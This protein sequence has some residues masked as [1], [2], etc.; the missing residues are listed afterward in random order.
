VRRR[1]VVGVDGSAQSVAALRWAAE[2]AR[3]RDATLNVITVWRLSHGANM[4]FPRSALPAKLGEDLERSARDIQASALRL[5]LPGEGVGDLEA[6]VVEGVAAEV[7]VE[8]SKGADMLVL[9]SR[10]FGGFRGLLLGSIDQLC[11]HRAH[12]PVVIV[13]TP[14]ERRAA[15]TG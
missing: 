5:A 8:A 9:G 11:T 1:I 2:E 13:R 7:L 4:I 14:D 15:R 6:E 12:C 10:G 3:L